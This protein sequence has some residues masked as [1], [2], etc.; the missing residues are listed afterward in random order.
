[1][2]IT[3]KDWVGQTPEEGNI[4]LRVQRTSKIEFVDFHIANRRYFISGF[5][6]VVNPAYPVYVYTLPEN[7]MDSEINLPIEP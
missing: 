6:P 4:R 5:K 1:M 2:F 3:F 7:I